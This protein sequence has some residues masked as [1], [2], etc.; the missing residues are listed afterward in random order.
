MTIRSVVPKLFLGFLFSPLFFISQPIF[1]QDTC[2]VN[3]ECFNAIDL[4]S[5]ITDLSFIDYLGCNL[6]SS[7]DTLIDGCLMGDFPTVWYKFTTDGS[8]EALT[9][10]LKS[11]DFENP[12]IS[13]FKS[14]NGG[15]DDLETVL[16]T[17]SNLSCIIGT[18][19]SAKIVGS[20][21]EKGTTYY[22][23]VSSY[24]SIGGDF[25]IHVRTLSGGSACVGDRSIEITGRENGGPLEG[26][27]DP[28]EKVSICMHVIE[29]TAANN[30]CQWFQGLVP[31]FGN[32]WDPTSFDAQAQ[33]LNATVNGTPIG[34]P[35]NGIY[36][37]AL[38]DW[39]NDVDYHHDNADFTIGDFDNN[40]RIE[41][42]N[43]RH[44]PDCPV[45]G[46]SGGCCNPCWGAPLGDIL[47]AGWFAYGING[48]CPDPGPPIRV[49][50]GDGNTCGG[51]M[52]P[53]AFC[54][55]LVTRDIPDCSVDST[56]RDLSLGFFTFA[57]GET[58]AWTGSSSVCNMDAP[59]FLSLEAKCGRV[60]F[61]PPEI[62]PVYESGDTLFFQ[63]EEPDVMHWE[64]NISP[65]WAVP[66]IQ[67]TG[68]NGFNLA[69][70]L[71]NKS[72][73]TIDITGIFIGHEGPNLV[74]SNDMVV[75]KI[76]F[77]L[78]SEVISAVSPDESADR[79]ANKIKVYPMPVA[80][81]AVLE[82]TFVLRQKA[83]LTIY[84]AQGNRVSQTSVLP[85][86]S[87]RKQF[88]T[89]DMLPGIYYI[90]FG[91]AEFQYVT[92][93]VKI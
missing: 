33:P 25:S 67:N 6:Y 76:K 1:G 8:A 80:G 57:D 42:C 23:A 60:N 79:H 69:A 53:W 68:D 45:E 55:D 70:P 71:I 31:S 11:D 66:Y 26:P 43:S 4:G 83:V 93:M 85:G 3:S 38:W 47:P 59:L 41:M 15:C 54:F 65:F 88:E 16:L 77:K 78:R 32:G 28:G 90:S 19:G 81:A 24:L 50:W 89:K 84:D 2:T 5:P 62:L 14:A 36:G 10:V 39:F 52:G 17:S 44:D 82:W 92:K 49:D 37:A 40:G 34:D 56:T 91:N 20:L 9:V 61:M 18:E 13:V 12:V 74:E 46:V 30:G 48:S 63:I 75:R 58:G 27:F 29:Y 7:P 73:E 86:N 64:W 72:G 35:G 87:N 22:I 51:G 21:I